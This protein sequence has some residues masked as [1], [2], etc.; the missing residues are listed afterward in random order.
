[1]RK[2]RSTH[3]VS[4][5]RCIA[6]SLGLLLGTYPALSIAADSS[7]CSVKAPERF[8][9]F[10]PTFTDTKRF[11]VARTELPLPL[12]HWAPGQGA[13]NAPE[14]S[15][16]SPAEYRRW[17]TI[18]KFMNDSELLSRVSEQTATSAA[19]ELFK[20]ASPGLVTFR[21]RLK[22]GCWYLWQYEVHES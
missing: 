7:T 9:D 4:A 20:D 17:P 3:H 16:L 13:E 10:L 15:T 22:A 6:M 19:I 5:L 14:R 1:M 18:A 21:F 8:I 11:A 2:T 12:L